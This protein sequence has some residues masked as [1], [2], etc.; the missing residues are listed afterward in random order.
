MLRSHNAKQE[1]GAAR[2]QFSM[3]VAAGLFVRTLSNPN[4][5]L[6]FNRVTCCCSG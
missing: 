1:V 3:L 2:A 6:G 5:E 4:L